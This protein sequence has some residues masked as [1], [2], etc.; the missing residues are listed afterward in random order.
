MA[1]P[2]TEDSLAPLAARIRSGDVAAFEQLFRALHAP[3]CEVVD[4]YV[5]SQ[6]VAEEI[7]QDLFMAVWVD[8]DRVPP[9]RSIRAYLF[10]SARNRALQH[11]RHRSVV[12][13]WEERLQTEPASHMNAA[14][15]TPDRLLEMDEV[16][17]ALRTA[18]D[19]LPPRTRVAFVLRWDYEMSN[20]QIATAMGITAKGA[21]KLLATAKAKLRDLLASHAPVRTDQQSGR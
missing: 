8:R 4:S 14:P 13:R 3:L 7:V 20:E 5:L 10:A 11:L 1:E 2:G 9:P 18:V 6:Q 19:Q 16:S 12:R 21:E 15:R 17:R